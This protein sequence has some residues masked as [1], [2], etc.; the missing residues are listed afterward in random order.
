MASG[1]DPH[2]DPD[3]GG[4]E[5]PGEGEPVGG[6]DEDDPHADDHHGHDDHGHGHDDHGS[7]GPPDDKWVLLPIAVGLIIGVIIVAFLGLGSSA[8]P[9]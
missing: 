7:H 9:F 2:H 1:H 3:E 8:S 6:Y 4:H 5:F